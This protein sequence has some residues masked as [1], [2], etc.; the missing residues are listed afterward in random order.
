MQSGTTP[1]IQAKT[2]HTVLEFLVAVARSARPL[3][4]L[5]SRAFTLHGDWLI[6]F[7]VMMSSSPEDEGE[8]FRSFDISDAEFTSHLDHFGIKVVWLT[9]ATAQCFSVELLSDLPVLFVGI[10]VQ[11]E[12]AVVLQLV[13]PKTGEY[14]CPVKFLRRS[15]SKVAVHRTAGKCTLGIAGLHLFSPFPQ[16]GPAVWQMNDR[17]YWQRVSRSE[18]QLLEVDRSPCYCMFP[19]GKVVYAPIDQPS[20]SRELQL[21]KP[22]EQ[23]GANYMTRDCVHREGLL[24]HRPLRQQLIDAGYSLFGTS[25]NIFHKKSKKQI[26]LLIHTKESKVFHFIRPLP[27]FWVPPS[28]AVHCIET[29]P[30]VVLHLRDCAHPLHFVFDFS[31]DDFDRMKIAQYRLWSP[32]THFFV[33]FEFRACVATWLLCLWRNEEYLPYDLVCIILEYACL[34][35]HERVRKQGKRSKKARQRQGYA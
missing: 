33:G 8:K 34:V 9:P 23:G 25:Q 31:R 19:S 1:S 35:Q 30:T 3:H 13:T 12:S 17:M 5:I 2:Q 32:N 21:G 11:T 29:R 4:I 20:W 18:V 22:G 26:L 14:Q 28:F 16:I 7:Q 10:N 27:K 15:A 6:R 24:S